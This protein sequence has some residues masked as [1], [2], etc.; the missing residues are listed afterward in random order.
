[1]ML[2]KR[3]FFLVDFH[4]FLRLAVQI[5]AVA[6]GATLKVPNTIDFRFPISNCQFP[7]MLPAVKRCGAKL[8][9]AGPRS[10]FPRPCSLVPIPWSLVAGGY[11]LV[12]IG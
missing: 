10:L 2:A 8:C 12:A 6:N 1:G 11:W 3:K 9:P 7:H 4:L 5:A